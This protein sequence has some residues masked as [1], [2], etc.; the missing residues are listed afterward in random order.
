MS[1]TQK[2]HLSPKSGKAVICRASVKACPVGGDHFDTQEDAQQY[3]ESTLGKEY[4]VVVSVKKSGD[5][6]NV[7]PSVFRTYGVG[8][9]RKVS[10][11]TKKRWNPE[12]QVVARDC[13]PVEREADDWNCPVQDIK[14]I[15][16]NGEVIGYVFENKYGGH[17]F[18][19]LEQMNDEVHRPRIDQDSKIDAITALI[20]HREKY[21]GKPVVLDTNSVLFDQWRDNPQVVSIDESTSLYIEERKGLG[22]NK[23]V[24]RHV[25]MVKDGKAVSFMK[26]IER[27]ENGERVMTRTDVETRKTERRKGYAKELSAYVEAQYG[28][29]LRSTGS[30]TELG[31]AAFGGNKNE[32]QQYEEWKPSFKPMN[33]VYD[34]D[35]LQS[36]FRLN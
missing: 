7:P 31:Y 22:T 25:F 11:R 17:G 32:D 29:P 19:T 12:H 24:S 14:E 28:I 27:E 1:V 5:T 35:K 15:A 6:H 30:F 26:T 9:G 33:F 34:W 10:D 8:T 36:C 20:Q 2:Y 18:S 3:L 4:G 16:L 21:T 23:S 13:E